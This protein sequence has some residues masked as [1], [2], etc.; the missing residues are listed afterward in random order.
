MS[1]V[2]QE[3]FHRENLDSFRNYVVAY[4]ER[5]S[6]DVKFGYVLPYRMHWDDFQWDRFFKLI[7]S[8][9]VP[10]TT[11]I[12]DILARNTVRIATRSEIANIRQRILSHEMY[13]EYCSL[14]ETLSF[15]DRHVTR[16]S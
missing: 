4:Q 3:H 15:L 16:I 2:E 12:D 10:S 5:N 13:F 6:R 14:Q 8:S 11:S 7:N 1:G 9:Q